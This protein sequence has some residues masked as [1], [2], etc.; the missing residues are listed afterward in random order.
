[1]QF[2][3]QVV[4]SISK[5]HL[6]ITMLVVTEIL[7]LI[8]VVVLL[9]IAIANADV[10]ITVAITITAIIT[11]HFVAI[12]TIL[13]AIVAI[14]QIIIKAVAVVH[15]SCYPL[16][17][18]LP[19]ITKATLIVTHWRCSKLLLHAKLTFMLWLDFSHNIL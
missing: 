13:V 12:T 19:F 2:T 11:V 6:V 14:L 4:V 1:M 9:I 16:S 18:H 17:N 5:G 7:S 8:R 3:I 10:I 15:L